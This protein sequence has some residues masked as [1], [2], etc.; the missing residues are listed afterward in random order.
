MSAYY[1][2]D[3]NFDSF[4]NSQS[5]K[6]QHSK[7]YEG[8]RNHLE[9]ADIYDIPKKRYCYDSNNNIYYYVSS[10]SSQT[11]KKNSTRHAHIKQDKIPYYI[12]PVLYVPKKI[13]SVSKSK[14]M[15]DSNVPYGDVHENILTATHSRRN[16]IEME[17]EPENVPGLKSIDTQY[18]ISD[19]QLS[20]EETRNKK[21]E[22]ILD[23]QIKSNV[24]KEIPYKKISIIRYIFQ[25]LW[26]MLN[27]L[28][29]VTFR[30]LAYIMFL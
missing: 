13:V 14:N 19:T 6:L 17:E 23:E 20:F 10:G 8:H 27:F 18:E 15:N 21:S 11:R 22:V 26:E 9:A 29:S 12:V 16:P 4:Y 3:P 2:Y 28:K 24:D 7:V 30:Y 25:E 5:E 1:T